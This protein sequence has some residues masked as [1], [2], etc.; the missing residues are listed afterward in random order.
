MNL[1]ALA[2]VIILIILAILATHHKATNKLDQMDIDLR[3]K[4]SRR[5]GRSQ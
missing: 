2:V 1:I 4:I 3:D 5:G